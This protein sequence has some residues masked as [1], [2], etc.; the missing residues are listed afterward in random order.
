MNPELAE[1][2]LKWNKADNRLYDYFNK[3]FWNRVDV[4]GKQRM[5]ED[6]EVFQR[7]QKEAEKKCIDSYQPFKKK[8]WILGAKLVKKPSDYCRNLAASETVYGERLREKM[9][10]NI[11]GLKEPTEDEETTRNDLFEKVAKGALQSR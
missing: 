3:T 1:K 11:P 10:Q 8:P 9:Y 6:L 5:A 2:I 4:Y 7:K